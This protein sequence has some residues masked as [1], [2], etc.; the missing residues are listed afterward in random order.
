[1]ARSLGVSQGVIR[2]VDQRATVDRVILVLGGILVVLLVLVLWY[3]RRG[4][5]AAVQGALGAVGVTSGESEAGDK[6]DFMSGD[7][8]GDG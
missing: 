1:M 4:G 6:L 3:F 8:D 2:W 5:D 7:G